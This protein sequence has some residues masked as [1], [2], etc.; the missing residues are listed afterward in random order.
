MKRRMKHNRSRRNPIR[1]VNSQRARN[2]MTIVS[3]PTG[4]VFPDETIT[5]LQI[6]QVP[7][8]YFAT[9]STVISR[10]WNANSLFTVE[11]TGGVTGNV[12]YGPG[13]FENYQ[14]YRVISS[15]IT[16]GI[17][18]RETTKN[19]FLLLYPTVTDLSITTTTLY[20]QLQAL[21]WAKHAILGP[22]SSGHNILTMQQEIKL[23]KFVGPHYNTQDEYSGTIS[24]VAIPSN[25]TTMVR[26]ILVM[27]DPDTNTVT[28]GGLTAR[29]VITNRVVFFQPVRD[30]SAA[31]F[32][33][34]EI[35]DHQ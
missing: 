15:K 14:R 35:T 19:Q 27:Y 1:N 2:R 9:A 10:T 18:S 20:A 4:Q 5:T 33:V 7:T 22:T 23:E 12:P 17:A 21:P 3:T 16:L 24:T 26:W 28:T 8:T 6:T 30:D 11:S 34:V 32:K 29:V 31:A 25:P 13:F